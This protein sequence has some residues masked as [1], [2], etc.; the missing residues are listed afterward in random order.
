MSEESTQIDDR[1]S[2]PSTAPDKS[3]DVVYSDSIDLL[4]SVVYSPVSPLHNPGKLFVEVFIELWKSREL[5]WTLFLRD[6]KAMYRQSFLG[7][8]WIFAPPLATTAV[9][10]FLNSQRIVRVSETPIPYPAYVLVGTTL[11]STFSA[12]VTQ[13]LLSFNAGRQVFMKLKVPPEAFIAAGM[14]RVLF[15]FIIRLLLLVPVFLFWDVL[16]PLSIFLFP[17]AVVCLLLLGAA[18]GLLL[19][20]LGALYQD[21]GRALTTF[22]GF[23]MY[24][25]P[26]V[27]PPAKSGWAA[28]LINW[29]PMTPAIMTARDWLTLGP[30]EYAGPMFLVAGISMVLIVVAAV[31]IRVAMP[32]LVARMGM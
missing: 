29:N 24:L 2:D 30:S 4:P 32:H 9:W 26:V 31:A 19:V 6:L 25:T 1:I 14:G 13:P 17:L 22:I 16:P 5:I 12:A 11:W 8:A 23:F 18:L 28:T 20:P 3:A 7:Y 27:F 10:M 15:D 21:V